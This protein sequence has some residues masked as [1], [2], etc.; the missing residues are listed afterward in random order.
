MLQLPPEPTM[1]HLTNSIMTKEKKQTA[2]KIL[3]HTLDILY[4][5]T[6]ETPFLEHLTNSLM[7]NKINKKKMIER[8]LNHTLGI[9]YLLTGEEYIIVRKN[10]LNSSVHLLTGEVPIR[11]EDVGVYFS[12]EECDRK[13]GLKGQFK[14]VTENRQTLKSSGIPL[15]K[16]SGLDNENLELISIN[17]RGEEERVEKGIQPVENHPDTSAVKEEIETSADQIEK[18]SVKSHQEAEEM[19]S[20]EYIDTVEVKDEIVTSADQIEKPSVKSHQEAEEMESH[21]YIDTDGSMGKNILEV[22]HTVACSSERTMIDLNL[23]KEVKSHVCD[24]CGRHFA[25]KSV[26]VVH[27]KTHTGEKPHKC[28]DC[29]KQF[30]RKSSLIEHQR[31]HTGEKPHKCNDCGKRFT[32]KSIL[33]E[34]RRTH[35]GEKPHKCD[36]C[37]KRFTRK[38]SLIEHLRTHTGERPHRCNECGRHFT[39]KSDFKGHQ[40]IHRGGKR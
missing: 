1:E 4:L 35:T 40:K 22:F 16:S 18:P 3:N 24:E 7:M 27:Q 2:E 36:E 31:T 26:L 32:Y 9:I 19:E 28:N 39:R 5:L 11:C 10:S 8:I 23:P 33:I 30:F 15:N 6:G 12:R 38:S 34:H 13:E 14:D 17:E 20:H 25:Y 21:E 29:E 37:G